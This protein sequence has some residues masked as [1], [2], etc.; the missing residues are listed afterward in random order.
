MKYGVVNRCKPGRLVSGDAYLF[1]EDQDSTLVALIDGLGS[2]QAAHLAATRAKECIANH[3]TVPLTELLK[4]CHQA[5]HSTRGAVMMLMR[6]DHGQAKVSFAGIGNIGVRVF[7]DLPIKPISRN[8]IVGFRMTS[9]REFG[10]PYT[11]GDV[12]ILHSDGV[13][14]RFEVDEKWVCDPG[15]D[16][17]EVAEEIVEN[18]G[19]DNDDVTII[20]VR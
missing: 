4:L 1:L 12:F 11:Q 16:L 13:S 14:T 18:Y 9:A 10:Y 6:V 15:T 19:R 2:G 8:G 3:P 17:Q 7:S 20:V 5:L